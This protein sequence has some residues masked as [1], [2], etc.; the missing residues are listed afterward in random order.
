MFIHMFEL[1]FR[2]LFVCKQQRQEVAVPKRGFSWHIRPIIPLSV[3][4]NHSTSTLHMVLDGVVV[5]CVMDNIWP[6]SFLRAEV[7]VPSRCLMFFRGIP[8]AY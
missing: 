2:N 4:S 8:I 6:T 1:V 5:R 3:P 7:K